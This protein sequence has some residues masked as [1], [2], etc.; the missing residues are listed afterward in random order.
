MLTAGTD[1]N[2]AAASRGEPPLAKVLEPLGKNIQT[3]VETFQ[4]TACIERVEHQVLRPNGKVRY[5]RVVVYE[6]LFTVTPTKYGISVEELRREKQRRH[7]GDQDI[8]FMITNGFPAAVLIF[9]PRYTAD[10][11]YELAGQ[12]KFA[13]HD[14]LLVSFQQNTSRKNNL[15]WFRHRNQS[16]PVYVRGKAWIDAS[17]LQVLALE[18]GL[19]EPNP[20]AGLKEETTRIEYGEVFFKHRNKL[21]WVPKRVV[22]KLAWRGRVFQNEHTFSNYMSFEVDTKQSIHPPAAETQ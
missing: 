1:E 20:E 11:D 13:G 2:S 12:E 5:T 14:A 18:T 10:F 4:E 3:F 17:S 19:I 21:F 16:W 9:H 6:Y 7:R 15:F 22:V 8:P